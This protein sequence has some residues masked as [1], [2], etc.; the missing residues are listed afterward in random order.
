MKCF[1]SG[2]GYGFIVPDAG[3]PDLFVHY[4]NIATEGFKTLDNAARVAYR[5]QPGRNGPEAF[6][7]RVVTG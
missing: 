1:D 6:D 3:G 7:V 5:V 4:S 2:R